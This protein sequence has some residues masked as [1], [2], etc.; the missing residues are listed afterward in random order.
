MAV[1]GRVVGDA[2]VRGRLSPRH[3]HEADRQATAALQRPAP[4]PGCACGG[5][6][7]RCAPPAAAGRPGVPLAPPLRHE[8]E[9]RFDADFSGVRLHLD[10]SAQAA[11]QRLHAS[12]YTLGDDI[13]FGAGSHAPHS[14][15]GR[16]LLAHELVHVLQQRP[17]AAARG[18][19]SAPPGVARQAAPGATELHKAQLA[20]LIADAAAARRS[21]QLLALQT[22]L[23]A[24]ENSPDEPSEVFV[25]YG[26]IEY[27]LVAADAM[28]LAAAAAA[29]HARINLPPSLNDRLPQGVQLDAL[30][31]SLS[32][33]AGK[34]LFTEEIAWL[35]DAQLV[36][37]AEGTR[38]TLTVTPGALMIAF[39]PAI[40][41]DAPALLAGN[42]LVRSVTQD[43]AS[44]DPSVQLDAGD[45]TGISDPGDDLEQG[46]I[47]PLGNLIA[48]TPLMDPGYNPFDDH[49]LLGTL[50]SLKNN[51]QAMAAAPKTTPADDADVGIDDIDKIAIGARFHMT[52][53]LP[54]K[55][56]KG[57][58]HIPAGTAFS[59]SARSQGGAGATSLAALAT[60]R[61]LTVR[62]GPM[63]IFSGTDKVASVEAL[64]LSYGGQVKVTKMALEGKAALVELLEIGVAALPT[65]S[66]LA[67][68]GVRDS[69]AAAAAVS[70]QGQPQT[71][72]IVKAQL[73]QAF[74]AAVVEAVRSNRAVIPGID[75][76]Q[77]LGID[78]GHP[79]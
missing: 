11:A 58:V 52:S 35:P 29:E 14:A 32:L 75:L 71:E 31:A 62:S 37:G 78:G 48:G 59:V 41:F 46:L 17:G 7:P 74:S 76:A 60:L 30:S 2:V 24:A 49:D 70:A 28:S 18:L 4:Q 12:A 45:W 26:D 27:L 50:D 8:M 25:Q 77:V 64:Q 10:S 54:F 57:S 65:M 13:V 73:E 1:A 55:T 39:S 34:V 36:T 5:G 43:F 42:V 67:Q 56:A 51:L 47:G 66:Q 61:D 3:E 68:A 22:A 21:D 40:E 16:Q 69:A 19:S 53:D 6:C 33:P 63:A 44:G 15:A 72:A 20:A 79:H 38:V 23:E 9:Q